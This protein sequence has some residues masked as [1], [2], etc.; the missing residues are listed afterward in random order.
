M[1]VCRYARLLILRSCAGILILTGD[2]VVRADSYVTYG[3]DL[4]CLFL[5]TVSFLCVNIDLIFLQLC[6]FR[7]YVEEANKASMRINEYLHVSFILLMIPC[8]V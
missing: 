5:K 4:I 8:L 2:R 6:I 7:E 3:F 1:L